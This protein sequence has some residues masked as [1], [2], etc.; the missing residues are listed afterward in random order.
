M[1]AS[2]NA[3][4]PDEP[5]T[6]ATTPDPAASAP[7]PQDA[8]APS[9]E[10]PPASAAAP[11]DAAAP[12]ADNAAAPVPAPVVADANAPIAAQLRELADG[13]FDRL[14]GGKKDRPAFDAYYAAHGYAPVWITDGKLNARATA[15]I[16]YLG[17]VDADGLD[18]ADYPVPS[19]LAS[20]TDP[21]ALAE[22]EMRLTAS[23]VNYAHHASTGRVHWSRISSSI[24]YEVKA[25]APADI[26]AA[27]AD[28][29][30]DV[31]TTLAGYE[32][33]APNYIALKAKLADLRAGKSGPPQDADRERAGT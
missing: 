3:A 11:A 26:L 32:P 28:D 7:A 15:A 14:I 22:A 9:S 8:T 13:K 4:P 16:A 33:Q 25:P 27:M 2:A 18:P 12:P 29:S 10:V 5:V 19:L 24:L 6:T 23:V 31:T 1:P 30:K 21:A 20:T 17:Q